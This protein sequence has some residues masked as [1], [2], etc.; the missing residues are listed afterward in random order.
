M[1]KL[2]FLTVSFLA[3]QQAG[4]QSEKYIR[5]MEER[6]AAIDTTRNTAMLTDLANAF[7]RIADAEKTQWLP[8]YYAALAHVNA[9]YT[10][11][12]DVMSGGMAEKLDPYAEKAELA[13]NKAEALSSNNSEIYVIR[14]MI[15]S[16]RMIADPMSR[17]MTY[18]PEAAEALA[19]A[20]KLDPSNPRVYLL[21]GQDK[22]FTPEQYGGS[23]EEAKKLLEEALKKY[24]EFKAANSIA[25][26]WGRNMAHYFLSQAK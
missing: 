9:G 13:L 11:I 22:L 8:Y 17:F 16:L 3:L 6:V 23:K 10:L 1:K 12:S 20:K 26:T 4:A 25:P 24:D 14:K 19:I 5:A 21:E 18:G 2:L 7:E 15:A